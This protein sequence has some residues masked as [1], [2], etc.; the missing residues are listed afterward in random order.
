MTDNKSLKRERLIGKI[1]AL[2]AFS[3]GILAKM[4][5]LSEKIKVLSIQT[6]AYKKASECVSNLHKP[7]EDDISKNEELNHDHISVFAHQWL[8][9]SFNVVNSLY[10]TSDMDHKTS[11]GVFRAYTEERAD[12]EKA[13]TILRKELE[14]LETTEGVTSGVHPG[15]GESKKRKK[16]IKATTEEDSP[17]P[18]PTEQS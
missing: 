18:D 16:K 2:E 8:D 3:Q 5:P 14:L 4:Q 13:L 11:I 10:A 17:D 7:L 1:Q 6:Q 15:E 9:R 12:I